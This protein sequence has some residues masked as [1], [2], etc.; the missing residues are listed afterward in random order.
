MMWGWEHMGGYGGW[1]MGLLWMILFWLLVVLGIVALLRWLSTTGPGAVAQE[2]SAVE[3][4]KQ[5]YARG[6]IG[7]EEFQE[8]LRDLEG[9]D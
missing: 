2:K 6:E 9:R 8:K 5:R 4:L 7:R 3:I 1:G